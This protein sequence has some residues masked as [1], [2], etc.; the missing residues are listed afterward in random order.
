MSGPIPLEKAAVNFAPG[1][2]S[3]APA[4]GPA[5]TTFGFVVSTVTVFGPEAAEVL[6]AA[7]VA[8]AV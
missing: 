1:G 6:L 3:F 4:T 5:P 8:L 7:S 2:T